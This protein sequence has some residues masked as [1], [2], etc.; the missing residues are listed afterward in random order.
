MAQGTNAAKDRSGLIF[1]CF[2]V[3][4]GEDSRADSL[5]PQEPQRDAKSL[6]IGF[7]FFGG[8][9]SRLLAAWFC[10]RSKP[11]ATVDRRS[12]LASSSSRARRSW[13]HRK[14]ELREVAICGQN[15]AQLQLAH[16]DKA[17]AI[18]QRELLV[19][20]A[21]EDGAGFLGASWRD[22]FP[23]EAE[24]AVRLAPPG[25]RRLQ[26][27]PE[28]QERQSLIGDI[29]GR[30]KPALLF[31]PEIARR[32]CLR[33]VGSRRRRR[34]S[35]AVSTKRPSS[36]IQHRH[37]RRRRRRPS[38]IPGRARD[39]K[40]PQQGCPRHPGSFPRG[41]SGTQGGCGTAR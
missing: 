38:S 16:D 25:F 23:A 19:L 9:R 40:D 33:M 1:A 14:A 15:L 20:V 41:S 7:P 13:L 24:A 4:W 31:E 10:R 34:P 29:I 12:K 2:C 3:Y 8:N 26:A 39:T 30:D 11:A 6:F 22:P 17:G 27:D 18:G 21:E 5:Q 36:R 35:I 32:A 37:G 28:T